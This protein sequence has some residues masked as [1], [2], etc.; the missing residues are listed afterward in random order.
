MALHH[1]WICRCFRTAPG[2]AQAFFEN[3]FA[4]SVGAVGADVRRL[5]CYGRARHSV[6]AALHFTIC[7]STTTLLSL[8]DIQRSVVVPVW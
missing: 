8:S 5:W 1:S 2:T 7:I 4:G 3:I 6:R